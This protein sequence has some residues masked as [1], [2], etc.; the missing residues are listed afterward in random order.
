MPVKPEDHPNVK[1]G[2]DQYSEPLETN[3]FWL[4][5]LKNY[6]ADLHAVKAG[7]VP[8][9][10]QERAKKIIMRWLNDQPLGQG[11]IEPERV[12]GPFDIELK[13]QGICCTP[14]APNINHHGDCDKCDGYKEVAILLPEKELCPTCNKGKEFDLCSNSFHFP[15]PVGKLEE[16][17]EDDLKEKIEFIKGAFQCFMG[18]PDTSGLLT[19][20]KESRFTITRKQ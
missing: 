3:G 7:S 2:M 13:R 14:I 1:S 10:D 19:F 11:M 20:L 15:E 16:K 8:V 4:T 17:E 9:D 6:E 18:Y 5:R 12:Y